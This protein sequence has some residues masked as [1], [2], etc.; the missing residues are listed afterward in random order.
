MENQEN[1]EKKKTGHGGARAG[2]GRKRVADRECMVSFGV[3]ARAKANLQA[4]ADER[5][6]SLREAA[7]AIF[8]ALR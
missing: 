2:A 4:W 3:S 7:N 1:Q 6:L 5:G 8:E